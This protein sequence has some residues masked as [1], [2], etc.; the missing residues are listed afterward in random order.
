MYVDS[1]IGKHLYTNS[2]ITIIYEYVLMLNFFYKKLHNQI[3]NKMTNVTD[4]I[5]Y[6][7]IAWNIAK[8]KAK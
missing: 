5:L 6:P 7:A 1:N 3:F 8:L 4:Y 2:Y